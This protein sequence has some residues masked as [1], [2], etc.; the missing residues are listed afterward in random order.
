[1]RFSIPRIGN[2]L[3][4][5]RLVNQTKYYADTWCRLTEKY[6]PVVGIGLAFDKTLIIVCRKS[7]V[8]EM[9]NCPEFDARVNGFLYKFRSGGIRQEILFIDT[10]I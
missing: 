5:A 9:L 4:I 1:M 3:N 7:A 2:I 8:T 10:D 6:G